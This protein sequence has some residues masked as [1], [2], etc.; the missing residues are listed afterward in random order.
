MSW[1]AARNQW[2]KKLFTVL[3]IVYKVNLVAIRSK[4]LMLPW[5]L[6]LPQLK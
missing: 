6:W 1:K 3:W 5:K 4:F 2:L